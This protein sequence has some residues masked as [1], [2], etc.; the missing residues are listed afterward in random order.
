MINGFARQENTT[1]H[2]STDRASLPWAA[3]SRRAAV[4]GTR[5]KNVSLAR[6]AL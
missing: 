3:G 5:R 2:I 6:Q 1:T 4:K